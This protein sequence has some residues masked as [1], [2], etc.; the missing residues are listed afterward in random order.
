MQSGA[1]VIRY[2]FPDTGAISAVV[3]STDYRHGLF[4]NSVAKGREA[5]MGTALDG[6]IWAPEKGTEGFV[7]IL[8]TSS[9]P[10]KVLLTFVTNIGHEAPA[11]IELAPHS[12]HFLRIDGLLDRS[13]VSGVGIR[14]AFEGQPG[15]IMAEASLMNRSTGFTKHIHF[16]DKTL[17]FADGK[18]W[19][20]F[21]LLG[22]QPEWE[23][24]P[25]GISFRSVAVIRN[26]DDST[27]QVTPTIKYLRDGSVRKV[28]L[29][30]VL[31]EPQKSRTI[32]FSAAQTTGALPPDFYIGSLELVPNT[33]R[34]SAIG[35]LFNYSDNGGYVVGPS[36]TTHPARGTTS[37][38]RI[39][40]TF[41]TEIAIENAADTTDTVNLTF[42]SDSASYTKT[43][44]IPAGELVRL[45]VRDLIQSQPLVANGQ[46]L[47]DTS[48]VVAVK[49]SHGTSSHLVIDQLIF[50]ANQADYVGYLPPPCIYLTTGYLDLSPPQPVYCSL[51]Q[52]LERWHVQPRFGVP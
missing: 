52:L 20:N 39:D 27:V 7:S 5:F 45:S 16:I 22:R 50:S 33:T 35:E 23:G 24:F 42:Y 13:Q 10:R 15:D 4:L 49:G 30:P 29:T 14:L 2:D 18:L 21:L 17:H 36:F 8:N 12:V 28:S 46:R 11:S 34:Q 48:G 51:D 37:L 6:V 41:Q 47:R 31:L 19:T 44:E 1:V 43:I 25:S 38:W 3:T 26:I 32:D 9:E 40:G